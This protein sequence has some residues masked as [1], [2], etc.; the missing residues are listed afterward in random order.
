MNSRLITLSIFIVCITS[1]YAV[2]PKSPHGA[3]LKIDCIVCHT[4]DNFKNVKQDGFN[5]KK[6]N[7]PLVGQ[8]KTIDCLK[9]HSTLVFSAASTEC[10]S[11]HTDIHQETVGL[12]CARCH[13]PNSWLVSNV[14]QIHQQKGF[15]LLGGHATA[16]CNRCHT[17]AS[18][19][20]F[21]NIRSDCYACH[22]IQYE[23]TIKPNHRSAGFG[24]DCERCHNMIGQSWSFKGK[25]FDHGFFPL[26]GRH[27]TAQCY[28][29][30][31]NSN[32]EYNFSTKLPTNCSAIECHG[33]GKLNMANRKSP[34]HKSKFMSYDCSAC[35]STQDWESSVKFSQHDGSWGKIYSGEHKGKWGSC[36]D[37]HSNDA[38]YKATCNKC[39]NF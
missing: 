29:C 2:I 24:I 15:V 11:C 21:D 18:K 23:T 14:K 13:K 38:N 28:S 9:C 10:S 6:T 25:G 17:S 7:F 34:A 1:N 20:R 26:T 36:T 12:D 35:H 32:G 4:T 31:T 22:Q 16:D 33:G 3:K 27:A 39:H 5:H 30:H 19:L 37:C 8:H